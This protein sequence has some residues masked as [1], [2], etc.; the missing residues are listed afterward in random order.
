[1]LTHDFL[2]HRYL[3]SEP[4]PYALIYP[5]PG[6]SEEHISRGIPPYAHFAAPLHAGANR[7]IR[8]GDADPRKEN[9]GL[10]PDRPRRTDHR[11]HAAKGA[12]RIAV[13]LHHAIR[14]CARQ[15]S[16]GLIHRDIHNRV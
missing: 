5:E 12:S 2:P 9:S 1:M 14:A 11:Y 3:P 16:V 15:A 4:R 8:I 10:P 7:T 13:Q 6:M